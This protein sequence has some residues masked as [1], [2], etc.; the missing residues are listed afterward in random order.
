[1]NPGAMAG[2]KAWLCLVDRLVCLG[3]SLGVPWLRCDCD[4]G[5]ILNKVSHLEGPN[6]IRSGA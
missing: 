1:M 5:A 4:G 2:N 3:G 6:G